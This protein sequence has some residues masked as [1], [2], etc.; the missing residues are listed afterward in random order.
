MADIVI[1]AQ[2][3]GISRWRADTGYDVSVNGDTLSIMQSQLAD[4]EQQPTVSMDLSGYRMEMKHH[5]PDSPSLLKLNAND[6]W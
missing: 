3:E 1:P 4:T 6:R 2:T 5:D